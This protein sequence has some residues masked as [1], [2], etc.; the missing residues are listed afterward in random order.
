MTRSTSFGVS[1]TTTSLAFLFL[2]TRQRA[3]AMVSDTPYS[4][5]HSVQAGLSVI[6]STEIGPQNIIRDLANA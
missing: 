1:L 5:A 6:P 3:A 4:A 2:E